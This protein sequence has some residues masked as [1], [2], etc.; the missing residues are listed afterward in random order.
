MAEYLEGHVK[1]DPATGEVALRTNQPESAPGSMVQAWLVGTT[2][3]GAYYLP[4]SVVDGWVDL[5]A[6]DPPDPA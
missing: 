6:P 4:T 3:R 5:Y 2:F 1:R